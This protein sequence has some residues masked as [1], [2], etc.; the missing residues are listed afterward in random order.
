MKDNEDNLDTP[1]R[2]RTFNYQDVSALPPRKVQ[3]IALENSEPVI[4]YLNEEKKREE[5][6][7]PVKDI[8]RV[9]MD[10]MV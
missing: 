10:T 3:K 9:A 7:L 2:K 1:K 8:M 6:S 5:V 4:D